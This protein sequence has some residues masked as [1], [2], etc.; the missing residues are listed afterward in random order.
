MNRKD[1]FKLPMSDELLAKFNF[2]ELYPF[3]GGGNF[4]NAEILGGIDDK[5]N[6]EDILDGALAEFGTLPRLDFARFERWRSIEKSCWLNRCYFIVPL[7]KYYRMTGDEKIAALVRDT[8]LH[9]IRN[10]QPPQTPEEIKAHLDYVYYIRDNDYNRNTYEDNQR[11]ETNVKYIWF[12]FQP[13]SRIIHFLY[14]MHFI[15]NSS[16]LTDSEFD[17]LSAGIK[18]HAQ[19]IAISEG[20]YE[21][22]T[23]PGNHQSIRGLA[24]LYAGTFFKDDFFLTE[25][26]RICRFHIENDYFADGVL[27][28]ISPS[29]HVF[30][31]WHVRDAY[32]LGLKHGFT[33]SAQHEKVLRGAAEFIRSMQQPDG[34]STVID[35]GYALFL[36]PFLKS[37]P[38]NILASDKARA[39]AVSYYPDAQLGFYRDAERYVC[40]DASLNPGRFSH[41]HAGKNAFTYFCGQEPI[42]I[43][44]GCCSYD[45]PV[46]SDY[47]QADS[48]S[49]LLVNNA[50]DGVFDGLYY[51]PDYTTPECSGWRNNEITAKISSTVA[52]WQDITWTR[53][54]KVKNKGLELSDEV[55]T[56]SGTE[57]EF[58]FIFNLHPN[59]QSEIINSNQVLLKGNKGKLLMS[60]E[61]PLELEITQ[62]S[63]KCFINAGHQQNTRIYINIKAGKSFFLNTKLT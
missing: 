17:E 54:L 33:V 25:G 13:A 18:A 3:D 53:T 40:F 35:D 19:L 11:S 42:F 48:H 49:A 30:E 38:T 45:D 6:A 2:F 27:K 5:K 58:T 7:A 39:Q 20:R 61:T 32:I 16:S 29:Y 63:G 55:E 23:S 22:L 51:C 34:C 15:K 41:Y 62:T 37:L 9:F 50:G 21:K 26:I 36:S 14:A 60:F 46:F 43:D 24:L 8:M 12:D 44:S 28:E 1:N 56:I 31:T 52:E 10:Y 59:I 47:K 57:K 4:I